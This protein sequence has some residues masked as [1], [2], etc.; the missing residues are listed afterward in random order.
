MSEHAWSTP[1]TEFVGLGSAVQ[2]TDCERCGVRRFVGNLFTIY[3]GF[4]GKGE[5]LGTTTAEPPC[6]PT[7]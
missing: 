4:K 3:Y 5:A 1:R 2:A 6:L 7:T